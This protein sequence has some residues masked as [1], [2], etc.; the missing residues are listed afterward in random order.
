MARGKRRKT[1]VDDVTPCI[2]EPELTEKAFRRK[3]TSRAN[4][5]PVRCAAEDVDGYLPTTDDDMVDPVYPVDAH[6]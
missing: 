5:A 1:E 6:F 4:A 3:P 2:L